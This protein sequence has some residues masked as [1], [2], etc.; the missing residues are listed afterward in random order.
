MLDWE[1]TR[2]T[3]CIMQLCK[4]LITWNIHTCDF[5]EMSEFLSCVFSFYEFHKNSKRYSNLTNASSSKTYHFSIMSPS[6][7][8]TGMRT[9]M[10]NE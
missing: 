10:V 2:T 8:Y 1:R 5:S 3:D 9:C 7:M 6:S 4:F